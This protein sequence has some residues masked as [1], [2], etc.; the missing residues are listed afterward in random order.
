MPK[1]QAQASWTGTLKEGEG[2]M[3]LGSGA[4]EGTF[5]F[6]TRFEDQPGTNP[7]ELLGAALA[8]C[9]SMA[10]SA[11]LEQAGYTPVKVETD[12]TTT[13]ES[14]E[15]GFAVTSVALDTTAVVRSISDAEFHRIAE[16]TK[17][18]C[19]V[20]KALTGTEISLKAKLVSA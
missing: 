1:R 6:G 20:S 2:R 16:A 3:K 10:L 19:P 14:V 5:S 15:G 17:R 4:F 7:E 13:V 11:D 9:Y 12:S 18:G 8:G